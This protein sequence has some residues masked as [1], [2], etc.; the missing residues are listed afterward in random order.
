MSLIISFN[1]GPVK[2]LLVDKS[3]II[4][5]FICFFQLL[6]SV[7]WSVISFNFVS[8]C[9]KSMLYFYAILTIQVKSL[10]VADQS[11][12]TLKPNV[13]FLNDYG[14]LNFLNNKKMA[15]QKNK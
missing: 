1:T 15:L 8:P 13:E 9:A 7:M 14:M 6:A 2:T 5:G 3:N 4:L 11:N 10:Y 12:N